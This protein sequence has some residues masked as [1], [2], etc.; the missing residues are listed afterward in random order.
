MTAADD[1]R[2]AN[3]LAAAATGLS[4]AVGGA[5]TQAAGLDTVASS[6]LV[7][8]LDFS[9]HGS[10]KVLSSILGVT[11]SGAVRLVDRLAETGLVAREP[12]V[13]GRTIAVTLTPWG[14]RVALRARRARGQVVDT[15]LAELDAGQR[16]ALAGQLEMVIAALVEQRLAMRDRGEAPAGGALCRLCDFG[17]CGRA[18]G[19][20][21]AA[22]AAQRGR[23]S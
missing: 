10:V 22:A 2:L 18:A 1:G 7:S 14:R 17:R 23:E 12:G 9:P 3:L 20:C 19:R 4:D 15:V 16:E 11:H 8:L 5:V 13:D 21:P 6:A